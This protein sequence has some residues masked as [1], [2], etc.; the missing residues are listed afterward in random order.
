MITS[1]PVNV[2]V[3]PFPA[4]NKPKDFSGLSGQFSLAVFPDF[5]NM[6]A[7]KSN[8]LQVEISGSGNF[9]EASL[10][11]ISWPAGIDT[12]SV[13]ENAEIL[14]D[15]F[16]AKGRKVFVITFIPRN[17]G[18]VTIPAIHVSYFDPATARYKLISSDSVE[19]NVLPGES[20]VLPQKAPA[21][22]KT[23]KINWLLYGLIAG[24]VLVGGGLVMALVRKRRKNKEKHPPVETE[25]VNRQTAES[26]KDELENISAISDPAV[27]I[28]SFKGFLTGYIQAKLGTSLNLEEELIRK[29]AK[30][31]EW[32]AIQTEQLY[33]KC[34]TL[35]YSPGSLTAED[36]DSLASGL[37]GI[38]KKLE[39]M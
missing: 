30:R 20:E 28:D 25:E 33:Q 17:E 26:F 38:Y 21:T 34:N 10:P 35:L 1:S 11:N 39:S 4:K 32:S 14:Q 18:V 37:S 22:L 29:L 16:P 12:F 27:F 3:N 5:N 15:S 13:S 23:K 19:L 24:A 9:M 6:P 8:T 7:G 31:D 2:Q 36:R